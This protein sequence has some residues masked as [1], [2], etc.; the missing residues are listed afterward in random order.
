MY[1]MY[2]PAQR[3]PVFPAADGLAKPTPDRACGCSAGVDGGAGPRRGAGCRGSAHGPW[4]R[5]ERPSFAGRSPA[6]SFSARA[7][8]R[9]SKNSSTSGPRSATRNGVLCAMR[10]LMK[11]TSRESRSRLA[12]GMGHA[13]PHSE[14]PRHTPTTVI[15]LRDRAARA[16][17]NATRGGGA[18]SLRLRRPCCMETLRDPLDV[19]AVSIMPPERIS[20]SQSWSSG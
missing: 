19:G 13:L 8:Y 12:T 4:R 18:K 20:L 16:T 14:G 5:R 7:T 2:Y 10:P 9:C 6:R 3:L 11:C 1:W 17:V 15:G